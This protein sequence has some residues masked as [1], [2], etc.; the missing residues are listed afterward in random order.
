MN[1]RIIFIITEENYAVNTYLTKGRFCYILMIMRRQKGIKSI[2][3]IKVFTDSPAD[4]PIETV[5]ELDI[6]FFPVKISLGNETYRDY[7][8]IQGAQ[9]YEKLAATEDMP[10]TAQITVPEFVEAFQDAL[11]E[12]FET[13]LCFT[14]SQAASGTYQNACLAKKM[15]EEERGAVD[16]TVL[17]GS[18]SYIYG[19]IVVKA[20]SMAREGASKEE[21]LKMVSYYEE[22]RYALFVV[23]TLKY[24]KKGG[25]INA[26]VAVIGELL[27]IK[28]LLTVK[29]GLVSVVDKVRGSK[30]VNARIVELLRENGIAEASE[31]YIFDGAAGGKVQEMRETLKHN[32]GIENARVAQ[33]G[34]VIGSHAGPGV[35]G[36]LFFK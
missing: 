16:I 17:A 12:G 19:G 22:N 15:V 24:L 1:C 36:V 20:A 31:V 6:G 5:K 34:P 25:R 8:D 27:N 32:F 29:D 18:L 14:I 2:P 11:D 35:V 26:T 4:I 30:R 23:D 21:I 7:I 9:F 3:K 28:P 10:T 13:L 33:V